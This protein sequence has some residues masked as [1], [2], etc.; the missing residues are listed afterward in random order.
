MS[1]IGI[2]PGLSG[3]I[4][5]VSGDLHWVEDIPTIGKRVNGRI[6]RSLICGCDLVVIEQVHSM[7]GQGVASTF[8]FGQA[9]GT[10]IG[11]A[12]ALGVPIEFV[13]P[14]VWKKSYKLGADKDK[15]RQ[16]ASDLWPDKAD[17]FARKKDH[18]RAD[19]ALLAHW[20]GTK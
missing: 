7:P 6:V 13:A 8:R 18:N 2:D 9:Y 17:L 16:I 3:A 1:V 11:V 10:L 15:A 19:A 14:T 4:A 12:E 20:G 5:C